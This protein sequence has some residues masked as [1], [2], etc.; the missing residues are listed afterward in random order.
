MKVRF[1]AAAHQ[2]VREA[3]EYYEGQEEGLGAKFLNEL[4]STISRIVGMPEAWK[5]LSARTRRCMFHRFPYGV[6][7]QP[8]RDE[9]LIL[10]I[11]NLHRQPRSWETLI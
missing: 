7:Y 4:E 9:I 3:L 10:S 8:G 11:M 5:P 6:I 2:E 1:T